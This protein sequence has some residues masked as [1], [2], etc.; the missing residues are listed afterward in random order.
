MVGPHC[1]GHV[2]ASE[3]EKVADTIV[4]KVAEGKL[5]WSCLFF[6]LQRVSI[7]R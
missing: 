6:D 5:E 2:A 4:G 3:Q 1:T 7:T